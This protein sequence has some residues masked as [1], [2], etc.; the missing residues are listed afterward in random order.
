MIVCVPIDPTGEI[1]HRWGRAPRV[2]IADV[3]GGKLARW[4]EFEVGWDRSHDAGTEGGHH[5]SVARFL[6]E[7]GV[8]MVIA[9]HMGD[10]MV[11]MLESM[12][13]AVRLG[14]SG[15]AGRAVLFATAGQTG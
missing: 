12:G 10:P 14:A 6:K 3:Q 4:E 1:D 9:E 13:V 5:A 8:Q 7:Q 11:R 2:A 15:D